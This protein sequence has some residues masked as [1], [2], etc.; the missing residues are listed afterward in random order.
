MFV[1]PVVF[2]DHTVTSLARHCTPR[3]MIN[4]LFSAAMRAFDELADST[5]TGVA[6]HGLPVRRPLTGARTGLI[7]EAIGEEVHDWFV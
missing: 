1:A 5:G 6:R 3:E 2:I 7:C 4:T